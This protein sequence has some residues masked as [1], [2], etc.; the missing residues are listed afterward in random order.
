MSRPG[1]LR[2]VSLL[3][4]TTDIVVA[5][6]CEG[7]LVGRSHECDASD[8][9]KS[10]PSCT[11]PKFPIKGDSRD[12]DDR[13]T[14]LVSQGLSVYR[15]DEKLLQQLN[16]DLILTQDHCE[17]C[18][19][20][21][22]DIHKAVSDIISDHC[23]VLSLSP[24]KL[25]DVWASF[26]SVGRALGVVNKA[27]ELLEELF[28][29]L[30]VISETLKNKQP[31]RLATIEWIDPL[32]TAGNWTPELISYA[33]GE[34]VMADAGAHSHRMSLSDLQN[35]DPDVILV[36]PCGYPLETTRAEMPQLD[37]N[38]DWQNLR[39][40]R[41]GNVA[42]ADGNLFFNRPGPGLVDSSEIVSE[43]LH[44]EI[45]PQKHFHDKRWE[46]WSG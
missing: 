43:I 36:I 5:F 24:N 7:W 32:M 4:A 44:P 12:I 22:G 31:V 15:V 11:E 37:N 16:P 34:D 27:E 26:R 39:A 33:G 35:Q 30:N 19:A 23:E 9:V 45:F 6:G 1:T 14:H 40:V 46:W 13:V 42:L 10:L 17:V 21:L 25:D 18:A 20:S 3:P 38:P 2:I 8:Y 28:N 41:K 29:R